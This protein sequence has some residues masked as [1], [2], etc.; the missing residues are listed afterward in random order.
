MNRE[1]VKFLK[2]FVR[3][4]QADIAGAS[5]QEKRRWTTEVHAVMSEGIIGTADFESFERRVSVRAGNKDYLEDSR[6]EA[7]QR[8]HS[9]FSSMFLKIVGH[10]KAVFGPEGSG[11]TPPK[12]I[13]SP[14]HSGGLQLPAQVAEAGRRA[15]T[16]LAASQIE[17]I[18]ALIKIF[19]SGVKLEVH[20]KAFIEGYFKLPIIKTVTKCTDAG[21]MLCAMFFK[22]L[23]GVPLTSFKWCP[24]CGK[25]FVHT[26]KRKRVFCS[27]A[28][29]ARKGGREH[30]R[31]LKNQRP[32][33]YK[34]EKRK[35]AV[36]A[37][38]SYVKRL[39][40]KGIKGKPAQRP[41]KHKEVDHGDDL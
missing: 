20:F 39:R 2:W 13:E 22:F 28:C 30:R 8:A 36:R 6:V 21:A 26:T 11:L 35:G 19:A 27:N 10:L 1:N 29:A 31:R 7:M 34:E 3:F 15:D 41:Y 23:D 17:S 12:R 9:V 33:A 18:D 38:R 37:R 25:M 5:L 32:E 16:L 24:E 4:G 40:E 14:S